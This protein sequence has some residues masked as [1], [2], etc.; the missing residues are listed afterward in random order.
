MFGLHF[1]LSHMSWVCG[2][3]IQNRALFDDTNMI[4]IDR[5]GRA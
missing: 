2:H 1:K 5:D 3:A 4:S